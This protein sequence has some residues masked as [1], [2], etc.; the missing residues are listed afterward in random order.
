MR[1]YNFLFILL[2]FFTS[3]KKNT[4]VD[5]PP[6]V[7][8]IYFPPVK[9]TE[10]QTTSFTSLGW[11]ETEMNNLYSYLEQ[12]GTK[13]FLILKNGRLV[14]ERYFGNFTAD[15]NWY[16]ASAGKTMTALLH[17]VDPRTARGDASP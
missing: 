9:G 3:C 8:A 16:W 7:P 13:A 17:A 10:W 11:N 6:P 1:N 12:N 15:S 14:T 2:L 5:N 4:P